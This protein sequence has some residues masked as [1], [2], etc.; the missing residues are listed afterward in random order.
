MKTYCFK[1]Y[2]AKRNKKLHKSINIAGSIYNHCIALHRRY[3]RIYGKSLNANKLKKHITRLKRRQRYAYWNNLGSQAI[4][5]I[6]ERIDRG[7]KLF[8]HNLKRGIKTAP[9]SFKKVRKYKSFTLKQAGYKLSNDNRIKIMGKEYRYH[10]SRDIEGKIKTVTVK[11]DPLG[12][13]YLFIVCQVERPEVSPRSGNIVGLDF[14]LKTFLTTS[15]GNKIA[16]PM[17]F[18]Q[19]SKKLKQLSRALSSKQKGSNNRRK[20]KQA[21]AIGHKKIVNQRKDFHFKLAR[22]L[23]ETYAAICIEDLSLKGMQK[24]WGKKI[25]DLGFSSFVNILEHQCQ[26]AGTKLVKIDRFYPSSKTCSSCGFVF[27]KLTL[28]DRTWTCPN[29]NV[30]HDRDVNAAINIYRVG[31]STLKGEAV[32]PALAGVLQ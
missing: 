5:D 23:A 14:G 3:Y 6:V 28:A 20:A 17:F 16:S 4:Q 7:Y 29:C 30:T 21:L 19:G 18:K 25:S 13:I 12:D 11:R 9:P 15:D 31:T 8:F 27:K 2:H 1:L 22:E 32:R 24:L 26:K 10:K